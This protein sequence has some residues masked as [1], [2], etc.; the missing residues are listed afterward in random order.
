M[1]YL[2]GGEHRT[3]YRVAEVLPDG[4]VRLEGNGILF[5]SHL[6]AVSD[7][8]TTLTTELEPPIEATRGLKPGYYN[9]ALVTDESLQARYRVQAVVEGKIVLD[10]PLAEGDFADKDNDGRRLLYIYDHGEGDEATMP[11]SVFLRYENG[12]LIQTGE[13]KL[14]GL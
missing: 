13:A 7:D 8:R 4:V 3:A 9:G 2:R 11:Q 14:K 5:R 6:E 1:L 12:K 10:R